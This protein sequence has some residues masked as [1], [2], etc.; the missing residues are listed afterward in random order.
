M[1]V[2][3]VPLE[4]IKRSRGLA[5]NSETSQE[6]GVSCQARQFGID[7]DSLAGDVGLLIYQTLN[8]L[9]CKSKSKPTFRCATHGAT[10]I[11]LSKFVF[12]RYIDDGSPIAT[13]DHNGYNCADS[14]ARDFESVECLTRVR[15]RRQH[16]VL[17]WSRRM[18]ACVTNHNRPSPILLRHAPLNRRFCGDCNH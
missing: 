12:F 15:S 6:S 18:F 13:I 5:F 9:G 17:A 7:G 14:S 16:L 4:S 3:A 1:H 2:S 10:D 11:L 8:R